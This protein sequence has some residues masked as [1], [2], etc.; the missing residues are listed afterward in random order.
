QILLAGLGSPR[1]ELWISRNKHLLRGVKAAVGVGGVL[2]VFAGR[3]RRAPA[4]FRGIGA[5]WLWRLI[6]EPRRAARI[7][8]LPFFVAEMVKLKIKFH[9]K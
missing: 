6:A 3:V 5:E 8:R 1:Q 9:N 2:D 4:V 7:A